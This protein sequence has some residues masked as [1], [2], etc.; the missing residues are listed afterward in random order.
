MMASAS[1]KCLRARSTSL[2]QASPSAGL[3]NAVDGSVVVDAGVEQRLARQIE[4]ADRGILVEIA[5]DVGELQRAPEMMREQLAVLALHAEDP[6]RQ[7]PDRARHAIAIEVE[8]R[9]S[10]ARGCRRR[11][12]SPCRR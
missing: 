12:P 7:P 10:S 3:R 9:R 11:C 8:R 1:A 6:H 2:A 4:P 5:Q